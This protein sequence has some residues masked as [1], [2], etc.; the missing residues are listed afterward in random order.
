MTPNM[1]LA[2]GLAIL[3][4]T[5]EQA[6]AADCGDWGAE[7]TFKATENTYFFSKPQVLRIFRSVWM[8]ARTST[9]AQPVC[10]SPT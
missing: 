9:R 8:Q 10:M 3:T 2:A 5:G 1:T 7:D 4:L 6:Q